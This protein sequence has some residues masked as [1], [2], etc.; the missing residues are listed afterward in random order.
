MGGPDMAAGVG[1]LHTRLARHLH[2]ISLE[3]G[4][5]AMATAAEYAATALEAGTLYPGDEL[6]R[7]L[8]DVARAVRAS[9]KDL[10]KHTPFGA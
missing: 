2:E 8:V 7:F 5:D 3:L 4:T 6:E 9:S 1:D 10:T